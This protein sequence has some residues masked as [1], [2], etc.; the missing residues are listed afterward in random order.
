MG[1][2]RKIYVTCDKGLVG[3]V[4]VHRLRQ[5]GYSEILVRERAE[6][7]LL[8]Y[9]RDLA[10]LIID[11]VGYRGEVLFDSSKPDGTPRKLLDVSRL[12]RLGWR[13][14]TLLAEGISSMYRLYASANAS[15]NK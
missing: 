11:I 10:N 1:A 2:I 14:S 7:D 12:R 13:H 15:L 3:S 8:D 9:I 6:L 4:I 5:G